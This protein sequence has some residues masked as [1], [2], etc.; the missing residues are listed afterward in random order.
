[1]VIGGYRIIGNAA[2]VSRREREGVTFKQRFLRRKG[3]SSEVARVMKKVNYDAMQILQVTV[4]F[5][6]RRDNGI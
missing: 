1:M 5:K 6:R 3:P 2:P 4:E